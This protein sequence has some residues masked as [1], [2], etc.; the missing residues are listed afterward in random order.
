MKPCIHR[1]N[2]FKPNFFH[3]QHPQVHAPNGVT[4]SLCDK[5]PVRRE[6]HSRP[7]DRPIENSTNTT[8]GHAMS[9]SLL[10]LGKENI[11]KCLHRG[12]VHKIDGIVQKSFYPT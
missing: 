4:E 6:I 2:E 8:V 3:C 10:D 7:D 9:V 1:G 12:R 5:C 11:K